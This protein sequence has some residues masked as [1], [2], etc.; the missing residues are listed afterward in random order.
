MCVSNYS[1]YVGFE[2]DSIRIKTFLTVYVSLG[3]IIHVHYKIP[4]NQVIPNTF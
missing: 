1:N 4:E 2:A 3:L